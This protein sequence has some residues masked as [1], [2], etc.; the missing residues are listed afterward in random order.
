MNAVTQPRSGPLRARFHLLSP[1][2]SGAHPLLKGR[3]G[4]SRMGL[5]V[6]VVSG[7]G[8]VVV[9]ELSLATAGA[10]G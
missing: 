7:G 10:L 1:K 8:V 5:H 6:G 2:L 9:V 4:R 3:V